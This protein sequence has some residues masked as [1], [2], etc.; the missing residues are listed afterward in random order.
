MENNTTGGVN[1]ALGARSLRQNIDGDHNAAVG[2]SALLANV[3]DNNGLT[4]EFGHVADKNNPAI[5]AIE[6]FAQ[7]PASTTTTTTTTSSTT[8]TT[9]AECTGD[10]DCADGNDCTQDVCN[11]GSCSN[12]PEANGAPCTDANAC[13]DDQC[14]GAGV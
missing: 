8:T 7:A 2:Y 9:M 6:I 13:T 4:I 10:G 3:D 11:A 5:K 14:D 12:P 1:T